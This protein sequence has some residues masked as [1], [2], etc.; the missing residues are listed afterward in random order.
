MITIDLTDVKA[1]L[2]L[3]TSKTLKE[4]IYF[5][6]AGTPVSEVQD[7]IQA[8]EDNVRVSYEGAAQR[9]KEKIQAGHY[10]RSK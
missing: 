1:A 6:P 4:E 2:A 9:V 7:W 10:K 3:E 5:F 8:T